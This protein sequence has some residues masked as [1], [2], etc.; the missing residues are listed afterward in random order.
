MSN[1]SHC[2][3]RNTLQDLRDCYDTMDTVQ[4]DEEKRAREE[5]VKLCQRIADDYGA[6]YGF[7]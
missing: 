1:Q 7:K 2:R 5:L 4:S 6:E 3:M